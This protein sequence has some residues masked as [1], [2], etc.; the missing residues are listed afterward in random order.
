MAGFGASGVEKL[1]SE[2]ANFGL[3]LAVGPVM[4]HA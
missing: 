1:M 2:V 4:T 3:S